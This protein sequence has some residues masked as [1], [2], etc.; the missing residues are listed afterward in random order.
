M[1]ELQAVDL[2]ILGAGLALASGFDLRDREVP[3]AIW[4]AMGAAGLLLGG[5]ATAPLGFIPTALWILV[6]ALVVSAS[7]P[8]DR[9][10]G[11]TTLHLDW[12]VEPLAYL[13][14]GLCLL[15]A[16]L[17]GGVGAQ[18]GLPW[19]VVGVYLTVLLAR[20]LF[21]AGI[22]GGG[23][24]A[25]ALMTIALF[26]PF[27][28]APILP[29]P[30]IA[31][32]LL[33]S[34]PFSLTVLLNALVLLL[35]VPAYLVIL[36]LHREQFRWDRS[37]QRYRLPVSEISRKFVW[38]DDPEVGVRTLGVEAETARE[39]LRIRTEVQ[40]RLTRQGV[41]TVWVTPQIPF[42]ALVSAGVLVGVL[43]GNLIF[44]FWGIL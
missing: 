10:P 19:S 5:V 8:W 32:T 6:G 9:L 18:G 23:A 7:I 4:L 22:L 20:G 34:V 30:T 16:G 40:E 27:G 38:V 43:A 39:D 11:R 14:V 31:T 41:Q 42:V 3:D 26:L 29:S 17:L 21:E 13:A 33:T 44:L 24:D 2:A 35:A 37:F 36:N 28:I 15:A 12:G 25:K 1:G